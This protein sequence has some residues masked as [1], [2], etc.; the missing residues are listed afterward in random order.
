MRASRTQE[1]FSVHQ[2]LFSGVR[3]YYSAKAAGTATEAARL[4]LARARQSLYLNVARTYLDLLA[5]QWDI[6]VRIAQL[7]ISRDRVEE[8]RSRERIGRSRP[9]EVLAAQSQ[10]A[11]DEAQLQGALGGERVN[12]HVFKF[13]TG[14]QEDM[15]PLHVRLPSA[16]DID[17]FLREAAERPDIAARRK[18]LET[19]SALVRSQGGQRCPTLA[20]DGNYYVKRP[21]A[22]SSIKWDA[23]LTLQVPLYAGG[24]VSA[25]IDQ[26]SAAKRSAELELAL[27]SRQAETEVRQAHETLLYSISMANT[28]YK[29]VKLG[30]EN[31]QAQM[32][33][34]KMGLV[35]NLDV[36]NALNSLLQTRIQHYQ[37]HV[38]AFWSSVRLSVAAGGP[39]AVPA[40]ENKK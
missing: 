19:A 26:A 35:T 31:T 2:S 7:K 8:L 29:A 36:L 27:A 17:V 40:V 6:E 3:D 13:I 34:Y 39:D 20:A 12:Q 22:S 25:Q 23:T 33:D 30:R 16:P 4:N 18:D 5:A 28:L 37:S 10:L 38:E 11:Q 14:V 15:T 21:A 24:Q 9:S 32:K 1:A